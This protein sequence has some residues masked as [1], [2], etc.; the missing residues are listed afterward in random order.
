MA[1]VGDHDIRA[2]SG[3][4]TVAA[5]RSSGLAEWIAVE[6]LGGSA[7]YGG[8]TPMI[9]A[10]N[11]AAIRDAPGD[12]T[13]TEI[14]LDPPLIKHCETIE[15]SSLR[16][17]IEAAEY[18]PDIPL[19]VEY[20]AGVTSTSFYDFVAGTSL[21]RWQVHVCGLTHDPSDRC[22]GQGP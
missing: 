11:A 5:V 17:T 22:P 19:V 18:Q 1:E 8:T 13:L 16:M 6:P 12:A 10:I 14:L 2:Y 7:H 20:G 15:S 4:F 9:G 3:S 21:A